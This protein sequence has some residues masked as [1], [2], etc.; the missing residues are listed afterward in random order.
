MKFAFDLDGT[1]TAAPEAFKAIMESLMNE[2][3][4]V[5]V[6]TGQTREVLLEDHE[7][8]FKQLAHYGITPDYFTDIII[9]GPPDWVKFKADYC[10][11]NEVALMF[12]ND[13]AYSQAISEFTPTTMMW[14]HK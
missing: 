14:V 10:R 9:A 1:I 3:H 4:E 12:E 13:P 2:G 11:D 7:A 8:R 6:L 5:I